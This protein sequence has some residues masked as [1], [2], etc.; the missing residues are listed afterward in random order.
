MKNCSKDRSLLILSN[1][2]YSYYFIFCFL[3]IM[4]E[5]LEI[6]KFVKNGYS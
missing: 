6:E 4:I 5:S 3:Y 2:S 1:D